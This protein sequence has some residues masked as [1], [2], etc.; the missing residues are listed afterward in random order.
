MHTQLTCQDLFGHTCPHG[1][2]HVESAGCVT[3]RGI[4]LGIN[5]LVHHLA[6]GHV[7]LGHEVDLHVARAF[8]LRTDASLCFAHFIEFIP[9]L[10]QC[11]LVLQQ[12][13]K[14]QSTLLHHVIH[15]H[16]R[17]IVGLA[18]EERHGFEQLCIDYLQ[19]AVFPDF[20]G[21]EQGIAQLLGFIGTKRHVLQPHHSAEVT[22]QRVVAGVVATRAEQR[23]AKHSVAIVE[24]LRERVLRTLN[25]PDFIEDLLLVCIVVN[26]GLLTCDE[27][28]GNGEVGI[29]P[30]CGM[31]LHCMAELLH[32][33][34][35]SML[36][37]L[38]HHAVEIH[39]EKLQVEVG[40]DK[41][42]E[43]AVVILLVDME[44]LYLLSRHDGKAVTS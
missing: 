26:D 6:I 39:V 42:R 44:Q 34:R 40:R 32:G 17:Q 41:R 25:F 3:S 19:F 9:H 12:F 21:Q 28:F 18:E 14:W 29:I 33:L 24:K 31:F 35:E 37:H 20:I 30:T 1:S 7:A 38:A 15:L 4:A 10:S 22:A 36:L 11:F 8:K 43:V 5:H 27:G 13:L 2:K 23:V 16:N